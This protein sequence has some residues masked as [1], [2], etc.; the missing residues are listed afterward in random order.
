[1]KRFERLSPRA[2]A[3]SAMFAIPIV[4]AL[5]VL[6]CFMSAEM[7]FFDEPGMW[8][9]SDISRHDEWFSTQWPF[10]VEE[11]T[12]GCDSDAVT[13][14]ADGVTYA[15]NEEATVRGLGADIG[16]IWAS[17]STDGGGRM[18]LDPI[19]RRGLALCRYEAAQ[20]AR[21]AIP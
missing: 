4:V 14:T 7:F 8:V 18:S 12:V 2:K 10:T 9:P 15:V 1:M 20:R 6:A 13:F 16:P 11:G 5:M 17:D 21:T 19:V 3:I